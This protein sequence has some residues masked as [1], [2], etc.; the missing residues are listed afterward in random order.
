MGL[1]PKAYLKA[2]QVV[3]TGI[4]GIGEFTSQVVAYSPQS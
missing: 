4:D 1:N 2:G 3:V